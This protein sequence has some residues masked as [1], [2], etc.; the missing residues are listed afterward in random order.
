MSAEIKTYDE[1]AITL[2]DLYKKKGW[3]T[4]H[5]LKRKDRDYWRGL[6]QVAEG[7]ADYGWTLPT[8]SK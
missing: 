6:A 3:V 1:F 5:H 8:P 2:Y 4:F 7:D